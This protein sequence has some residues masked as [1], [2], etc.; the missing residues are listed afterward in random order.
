M[1]NFRESSTCTEKKY[2]LCYQGVMFDMEPEL[3]LMTLSF[4]LPD[5]SHTGSRMSK[6]S[7]IG[8][9]LCVSPLTL[10]AFM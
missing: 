5:P 4:C 3:S 6:S 2:I 8:V 7:V 1:I 9:F 10:A